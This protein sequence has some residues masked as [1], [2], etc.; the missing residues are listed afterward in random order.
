[1]NAKFGN[2][3]QL[4]ADQI[5]EDQYRLSDDPPRRVI[6]PPPEAED[7]LTVSIWELCMAKYLHDDRRR[8]TLINLGIMA[9]Y[10]PNR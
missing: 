7:S 5:Q 6:K 8:E 1:M 9:G 4:Q 2:N 3:R 10:K